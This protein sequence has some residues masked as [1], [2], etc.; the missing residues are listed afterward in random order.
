MKNYFL[1]KELFL[2]EKC[3]IE[4]FAT[5]LEM[6][7]NAAIEARVPVLID[8]EESWFMDSIEEHILDLMQKFNHKNCWIFYTYQMYRVNAYQK[9]ISNIEYARESGFILGAKLVRGAYWEKELEFAKEFSLSPLVFEHKADTDMNFDSALQK[10]LTNL[11]YVSLVCATHNEKSIQLLTSLM[12]ANGLARNDYRIW[13]SQLYGMAD[14]ITNSLS[15]ESYNV[16]KYLPVGTV[17]ALVPYLIRRAEE[18]STL[19]EM[20][21]IEKLKMNLELERRNL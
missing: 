19:N 21:R 12:T 18:N 3:E 10:I 13:F 20:A 7:C 8:S 14:Y 5:R 17:E 15:A 4:S 1:R 2:S 16:C 6:I 9:L 11:K